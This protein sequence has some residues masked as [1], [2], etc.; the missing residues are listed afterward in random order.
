MMKRWLILLTAWGLDQ[1]LG[2]AITAKFASHNAL[3]GYL[4]EQIVSGFRSGC[5]IGAQ[6]ATRDAND[7]VL[8]VSRRASYVTKETCD[9]FAL[10]PCLRCGAIVNE[11]CCMPGHPS[12][13]CCCK[14][15]NVALCCPF[16]ITRYAADLCGYAVT[17]YLHRAGYTSDSCPVRAL[18]NAD[19]SCICC[20]CVDQYRYGPTARQLEHEGLPARDQQAAIEKAIRDGDSCPICLESFAGPQKII[21]TPC[22]HLFHEDCYIG[23]RMHSS[24]CPLCRRTQMPARIVAGQAMGYQQQDQDWSEDEDQGV[25][26]QGH[27]GYGSII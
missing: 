25:Q 11:C 19:C 2:A 6:V 13:P 14:C 3:A 23:T 24:L 26:E 16:V 22:N 20:C 15:C 17:T 12:T 27:G 8:D 21:K 7:N 5:P 9:A 4:G 1:A 10:T 18:H